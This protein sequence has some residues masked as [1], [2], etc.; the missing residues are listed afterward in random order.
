M[1]L[2]SVKRLSVLATAAMITSAALAE[3]PSCAKATCESVR[4]SINKVCA[5]FDRPRRVLLT[6]PDKTECWCYCGDDPTSKEV[7][8]DQLELS[9]TEMY[10]K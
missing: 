10:S 6:L 4:A 1:K 5:G 2:L 7:L 3:S 8:K 9:V